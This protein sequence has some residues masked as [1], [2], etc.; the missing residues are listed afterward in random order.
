MAKK[1]TSPAKALARVRASARRRTEERKEIERKGV[2]KL[3][4]AGTAFGVGFAEKQMPSDLA[5]I[6]TKLIGA[7]IAYLAAMFTKGHLSRAAEGVGDSLI[8]VYGYKQGVQRESGNTS[9]VAGND[10]IEWVVES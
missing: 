10:S 6:P 9:L 3:A 4:M 2:G 8:S 7:G 1:G 5:G